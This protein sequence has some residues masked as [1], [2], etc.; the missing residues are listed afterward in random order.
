MHR[1][2][3]CLGRCF[4]GSYDP[5]DVC[6]LLKPLAFAFTP[7]AEK[8]RLIQ[9]GQ[10]HYSELLS[11]ES[12]PSPR[13]LG[14]FHH[15]LAASR[16]AMAC[17]L[18]DLAAII[19][20]GHPDNITL[21]SLA[22]AG[23]PVGV[24]L[25][26]ALNMA[27]ARPA[28]HFS[29]SIL[30]DH[31][32]DQT[33]LRCILSDCGR[34]PASLVF[35][36]GWTGKGTIARELKRSIADFNARHGVNLS[37][38]LYALADLAGVA[39]APCDQDYLIPS[40]IMGATLSGLISRSILSADYDPEDFHGCVYYADYQQ[41][42][43]SRWFVA[44]LREAMVERLQAGYQPNACVVNP[45]RARRRCARLRAALRRRFGIRDRNL[46]K[47]GIGEATRV[48][49]RRLPDRLILRDPT[50]PDIGHLLELAR[51]KAVFVEVD[52]ALPYQAVALIKG[53]SDA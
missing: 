31:G 49:L 45:A 52:A 9:S 26:H 25:K 16:D 23:T 38:R 17:R 40:C 24:L 7:V 32:I 48:L 34:D 36:D 46:I 5:D 50:H 19:A 2:G 4:S 13:Y 20:A 6:F 51:E 15:A 35:V 37:P 53:L 41:H 3:E 43:L 10:R 28:C 47:P 18:L 44:R 21:V 8:E 12:A 14:I 27:F 39:I 30:R 29:I 11:A 1:S 42:D 33:A 22:R